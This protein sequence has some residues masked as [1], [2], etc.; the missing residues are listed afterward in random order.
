MFLGDWRDFIASNEISRLYEWKNCHAQRASIKKLR[1]LQTLMEFSD[2]SSWTNSSLQ[3]QHESCEKESIKLTKIIILQWWNDNERWR[4]IKDDESQLLPYRITPW[5]H[6]CW[7]GT[8]SSHDISAKTHQQNKNT[9]RAA[10]WRQK[11]PLS[12]PI[13]DENIFLI[14]IF[15]LSM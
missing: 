12:M 5:Q 3:H 15:M 11:S 7:N 14:K 8:A 1:I 2:F 13:H 4:S 6:C 9:E 10:R